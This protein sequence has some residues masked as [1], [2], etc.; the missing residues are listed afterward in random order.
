[1][2]V[3]SNPTGPVRDRI[4][5]ATLI[6]QGSAAAR[7]LGLGLW[8]SKFEYGVWVLGQTGIASFGFGRP[9]FRLKIGIRCTQGLRWGR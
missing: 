3:S 8:D 9:T 5:D 4:P 1:M 7:A 2:D 6:L